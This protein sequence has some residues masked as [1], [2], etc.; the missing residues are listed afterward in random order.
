MR[1]YLK[2]KKKQF[3]KGGTQIVRTPPQEDR[4]KCTE[5]TQMEAENISSNIEQRPKNGKPSQKAQ[6]EK[7]MTEVQSTALQTKILIKTAELAKFATDNK[8]VHKEVKRW[9]QEIHS[10]TKRLIAEYKHN[11]YIQIEDEEKFRLYREEQEKNT[12]A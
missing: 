2:L 12:E 1:T 6:S 7:K 3:S 9:S 8:N 10:L 11:K 5:T 4:L